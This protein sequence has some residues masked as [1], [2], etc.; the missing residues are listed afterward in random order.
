MKTRKTIDKHLFLLYLCH[1][2]Y[3]KPKTKT[4]TNISTYE[5][6]CIFAADIGSAMCQ[7]EVISQRIGL[8][9]CR[10][11]NIRM[12]MASPLFVE[13]RGEMSRLLNDVDGLYNQ[14][15]EDFLTIT[16]EN[17]RMF[18]AELNLLI[19]T[20]KSLKQDSL[21]Y[22][23]YATQLERLS[24]QIADLEE[25]EH[26]IIAFRVKAPNNPSLNEAMQMVGRLDFAKL[27]EN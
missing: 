27:T 14:L 21:T 25:L 19:D 18:G 8:I 22:E 23:K 9:S 13:K 15:H 10:A 1:L 26:D 20:L 6:N 11:F 17:Y 12:R 16:E 24:L 5:N 2:N 7:T 3:V 4:M